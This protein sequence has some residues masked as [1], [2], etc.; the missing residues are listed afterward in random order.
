VLDNL[1]FGF[2]KLSLTGPEEDVL[3]NLLTESGDRIHAL[4]KNAV[5]QD[6]QFQALLFSVTK[7]LER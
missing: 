5:E 2:S 4:F 7:T 3:V 6:Q 1:Q